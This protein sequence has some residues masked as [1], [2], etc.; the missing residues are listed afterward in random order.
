MD[1]Y[2]SFPYWICGWENKS[3][4]TLKHV[5]YS[6]LVYTIL[7]ISYIK[8]NTP[9]IF[10]AGKEKYLF[11]ML[12][13]AVNYSNP[14]SADL[15]FQNSLFK[16]S[17]WISEKEGK[18]HTSS[19]FEIVQ[20]LWTPTGAI[21][22]LR[23]ATS[24][25]R[26]DVCIGKQSACGGLSDNS[27]GLP[28]WPGTEVC[29]L[30][31]VWEENDEADTQPCVQLQLLWRLTCLH[32]PLNTRVKPIYCFPV[33]TVTTLVDSADGKMSLKLTEVF[34]AGQVWSSGRN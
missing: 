14:I 12:N 32:L 18:P 20:S 17:L 26:S 30:S 15:S 8:T 5:L 27:L 21:D 2:A 28:R 29:R 24:I 3:L 13:F 1:K 31:R 33:G 7:Y 25:W 6:I 23:R 19:M 4:R 10:S 11:L 22:S 16:Q 9:F 34:Y